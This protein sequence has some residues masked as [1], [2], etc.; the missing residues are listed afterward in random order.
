[1][2]FGAATSS[3]LLMLSITVIGSGNAL[4]YNHKFTRDFNSGNNQEIQQDSTMAQTED[5]VPYTTDH[6]TIKYRSDWDV[7]NVTAHNVTFKSPSGSYPVVVHV[8]VLN[9]FQRCCEHSDT[10][11]TCPVAY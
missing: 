7:T 11:H 6:Y 2:R 9:S 1:M 3:L 8:S 4:A 5:F 10:L